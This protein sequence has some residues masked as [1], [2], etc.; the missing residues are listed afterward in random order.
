MNTDEY[1]EK[2]R[3]IQEKLLDYLEG[4][5]KNTNLY[6]IFKDNNF[7]DNQY[8]IISILH[9]ISKISNDHHRHENFFNKIFQI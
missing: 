1:I 6:D 2:M 4:D 3:K 7:H 5:G 8:Y 9:L